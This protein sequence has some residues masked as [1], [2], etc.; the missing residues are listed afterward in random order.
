M[1][2]LVSDLYPI[3]RSITG[4]G[5]R[6][7]LRRLQA[8][9]PLDIHEVSTGTK[10]FDWEVPKE[11]QIHDAYIGD[12][13]G[14]RIVDFKQSNLH[15]VSG[16]VPINQTIPWSALKDHLHTLPDQPELV[17]YRT[18]F[19]REDWGFCLRHDLY[20]RLDAR[21]D[22]SYEVCIDATLADG[23]L[24]Y[25]E[26]YLAGE[27]RSEVLFSCHVCHPSLAN[28][29]LSGIAVATFLAKHLMQQPRRY[30][31]RILF[32][33][34]TIGAI[35]WLSLNQEQTSQVVHGLVLALLGDSGPFTYRKSRRGDE[36]I[37]RVVEHVLQQSGGEN[38]ILDF[39]P[40][41]YDQRQFCSPGFDLP[42]GCLMRSADQMF[43][44]YHTSAD[45]L[46]LVQPRYLSESLDACVAITDTLEAD[47]TYL[48][49][50]PYGEPRLGE[51]GLY[52]AFGSS[53]DG[54]SAQ[55]ATLWVLNLS[56][57]HHSLLDIAE[58][59]GSTFNEIRCAAQALIDHELLEE[60]T[61]GDR[62]AQTRP[63]AGAA[64]ANLKSYRTRNSSA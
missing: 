4:P 61:G 7:T 46:D 17:P 13:D 39:E 25:G 56:D 48:N 8:H 60:I 9:V 51:R 37:D 64:V 31:Y 47:R 41:G 50:N 19:H 29:N 5:V 22:Q 40:F 32:I 34:A 26:F 52:Q 15:V 55:R 59:S 35:T 20:E 36:V 3:C 30:S 33:P 14:D 58:R 62:H 21:G 57:G 16:S 28:D 24:T 1:Y 23:S 54:A 6:E 63:P 2:G 42:M 27:S 53:A 43:S 44:E 12:T 11:W 49:R 38:S 10:V 45:N 18:C